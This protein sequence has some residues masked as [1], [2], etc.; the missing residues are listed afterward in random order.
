MRVS[1]LIILA[2]FTLMGI[3]LV[4]HSIILGK[5]GF[6][7]LG[8]PTLHPL[9]FYIGKAA[10]F[11]TWIFL[12]VN[13]ILVMSGKPSGDLLYPVPSAILASVGS[14]MLILAFR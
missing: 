1:S 11:T 5:K 2:G 9:F 13:A 8:K 7:P 6:S 10:L 12:I 4:Y 14:V 3:F